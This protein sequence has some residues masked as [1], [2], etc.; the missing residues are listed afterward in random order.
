MANTQNP[1]TAALMKRAYRRIRDLS[2]GEILQVIRFI[3]SLDDDEFLSEDERTQ[4]ETSKSDIA[5][6]RVHTLGEFNEV[7]DALP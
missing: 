6:G 5:A 3:D 4:I 7:I 2:E 1:Q